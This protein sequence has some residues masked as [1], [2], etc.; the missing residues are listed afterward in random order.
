MGAWRVDVYPF[1]SEVDM[2]FG[3]GVVV[4]LMRMRVM[5]VMKRMVMMMARFGIV[6]SL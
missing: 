2:V 5:N 1:V 3:F 4:G 6:M